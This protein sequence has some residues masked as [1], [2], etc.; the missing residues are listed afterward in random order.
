[1]KLAMPAPLRDSGRKGVRKMKKLT[2][3]VLA[4]VI[5]VGAFAADRNPSREHE[6][7]H[8]SDRNSGRDIRGEVPMD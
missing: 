7:N 2:A 3:M 5:S 8:A 1:M 6:R 4:S